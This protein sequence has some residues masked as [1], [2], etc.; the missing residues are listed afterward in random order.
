MLDKMIKK[1]LKFICQKDES[2]IIS[3]CE[4]CQKRMKDWKKL[5]GRNTIDNNF[6]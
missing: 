3:F 5:E 6:N 2:W 4:G 1:V